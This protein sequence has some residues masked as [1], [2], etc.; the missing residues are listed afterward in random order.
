LIA[1]F[2]LSSIPLNARRSSDLG[3][4]PPDQPVLF[5]G[6]QIAIPVQKADLEASCLLDCS[7]PKSPV[8]GQNRNPLEISRAL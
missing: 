1:D 4:M 8:S 2:Q 6:R 7:P 5:R 3:F